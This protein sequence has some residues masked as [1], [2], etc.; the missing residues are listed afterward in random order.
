M[1]AGDQVAVPAQHGLRAD[2][3]PNIAEHVSGPP[4]QQG[5]EKRPISRREPDLLAVQLPLEDG[6]LMASGQNF[7]V[8]VP[9]A[10]REEPQQRERVGHA[11]IG[12]SK[13]HGQA[14][15]PSHRCRS[16][17]LGDIDQRKLRVGG[18]RWP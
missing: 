9:V 5:G 16:D 1:P 15:S 10:H 8:F 4:V 12:Q 14:S 3:Q 6:D 11:E 18:S 17:G 13:Q 2:Q 7:R